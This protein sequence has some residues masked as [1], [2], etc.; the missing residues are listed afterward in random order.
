MCV[1]GQ[2]PDTNIGHPAYYTVEIDPTNIHDF[3]NNDPTKNYQKYDTHYCTVMHC[4]NKPYPN[5]NN[6]PKKFIS[7]N[8]DNSQID[9]F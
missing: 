3:D 6:D 5:P 9:I 8:V 2:Y 4:G 1:N 7:I